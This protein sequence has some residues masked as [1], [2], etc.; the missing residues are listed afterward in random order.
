MFSFCFF[1]MTCRAE[2]PNRFAQEELI[3]R[4]MWIMAALASA[5]IYGPM[6]IAAMVPRFGGFMATF[7]T[8]FDRIANQIF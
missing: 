7:T 5:V 4:S 6:S 1:G 8:A 3:V 2:F